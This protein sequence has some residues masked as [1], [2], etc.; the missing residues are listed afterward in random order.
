MKNQ[1]MLTN[2]ELSE[3]SEYLETRNGVDYR[4]L[5]EEIEGIIRDNELSQESQEIIQ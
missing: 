4:V 1:G 5:K 3:L 2:D